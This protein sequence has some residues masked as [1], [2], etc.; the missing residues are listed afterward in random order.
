MRDR[1]CAEC[2]SPLLGR[3][4]K[5]FCEDACR[6]AFNNKLNSTSTNFMRNVNNTLVKNR[7]I[8][9]ESNPNGKQKTH[10]D[11]LLKRGFDFNYYTHSYTTRSGDTYRFCYEQGYLILDEGFVLLVE[12]KEN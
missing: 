8:L 4:D 11:K 7:R 12:R 6:N 3:A 5:K 2:G 1:K 9:K 10:R